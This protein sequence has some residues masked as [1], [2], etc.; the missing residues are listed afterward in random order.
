MRQAGT[1]GYAPPGIGL[2]SNNALGHLETDMKNANLHSQ[3]G[4]S[5]EADRIE[6]LL[7]S[8]YQHYQTLKL[9]N[10]LVLG[11][12]TL[13]LGFL[14]VGLADCCSRFSELS[15]PEVRELLGKL[16]SAD[17]LRYGQEMLSLR[18]GRV[19]GK[20]LIPLIRYLESKHKV[21]MLGEYAEKL[22]PQS[23]PA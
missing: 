11:L 2:L 3:A 23:V 6:K 21:T 7:R 20:D 13:G 19:L 4:I 17:E 12:A 14:I 15:D 10:V 1:F 18:N 16:Q 9:K 5:A 8:C 22:V